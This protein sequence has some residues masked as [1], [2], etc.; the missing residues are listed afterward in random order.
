MGDGTLGMFE[1]ADDDYRDSLDRETEKGRQE[2][3]FAYFDAKRAQVGATIRCP[4]CHKLTVKTTYHKVFCS[5]G[6]TKGRGNCKDKYWNFVPEDR[7]MR[8]SMMKKR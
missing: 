2:M 3:Q 4:V 7:R 1:A 5:N 6:R 8:A